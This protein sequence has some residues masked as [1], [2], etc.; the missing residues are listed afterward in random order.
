M[1]GEHCEKGPDWAGGCSVELQPRAL[2]LCGRCWCSLR[3]RCSGRV[4]KG[5]ANGAYPGT[6][7]NSWTSLLRRQRNCYCRPVETVGYQGTVPSGGYLL[8]FLCVLIVP[9]EGY[10]HTGSA[11]LNVLAWGDFGNSFKKEH[12]TPPARIA[13]VSIHFENNG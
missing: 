6:V 9:R 1:F 10:V 8:I 11:F 13:L 12:G 4:K 7:F 3:G 2:Q 5:G